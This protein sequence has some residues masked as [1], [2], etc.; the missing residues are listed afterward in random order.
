MYMYN[1]MPAFGPP[2]TQLEPVDM[3]AKVRADPNRNYMKELT[4]LY[5]WEFDALLE[6]VRPF[7]E[8]TRSGTG[9]ARRC[10]L[11]TANRLFWCLQWLVSGNTFRQ[12]EFMSGWG[13]SSCHE[14][15]QHVLKALLEALDGELH[16]PAAQERA[17]LGA[18][19]TG[20]FA[21]TIAMMDITEVAF[22][23]STC[24]QDE[25]DTF[26]K[27]KGGHTLKTLSVMDARG[28]FRWVETDV[29][30]QTPD[31]P[32]WTESELYLEAGRFFFAGEKLASDGGF[33]GDGPCHYSFDRPGA[34]PDL[35]TYNAAFNEY[36]KYKENSYARVKA[37]FPI[38]GRR[39]RCFDSSR[40]VFMLVIHTTFRL[41]N[42]ML[43]IRNL[44]YS[45]VTNPDL[46]FRQYF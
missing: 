21:G 37:W 23:R 30:G 44:N 31:R 20:I 46:L 6:H 2:E 16:W 36:R 34:C 15:C 27:K 39:R 3:V 38:L 12:E 4:S 26:S 11:D 35:R 8:R 25:K 14:D 5:L 7:I 22:H 42:W 19:S 10:K 1:L 32:M 33:R 40:S 13:K 9:V 45:P 41:H 28:F 17:L 18:E 43:R 24:Q 29:G